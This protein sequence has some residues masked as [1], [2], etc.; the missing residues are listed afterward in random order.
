LVGCAGDALALERIN[1]ANRDLRFGRLTWS[2]GTLL[3]SYELWCDP[4]VPETLLHAIRIMMGLADDMDDRLRVQLGGR[5]F[6]DDADD[7]TRDDVDEVP[8][9]LHPAL[10]TLFQ[11]TADDTPLTPDEVAQVCEYDRDLVLSFIGSCEQDAIAWRMHAE[12][13]DDPEEAEVARG[14]E[15]AALAH[16]DLLR[17]ALRVIVLD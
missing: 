8:D 12:S 16:V 7:R 3:A 11:L 10:N 1:R 17:A 5:R 9:V 15:A 6:F 14:E 2:E 4:F 13:C